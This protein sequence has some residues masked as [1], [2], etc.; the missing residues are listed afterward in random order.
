MA[1]PLSI[2]TAAAAVRPDA[3]DVTAWA[4]DQRV[5]ISSVMGDLAA[6]RRAV[7]ESIAKLGAYPVW[8]EDFGGRDDD[9]QAAYL[10][11]VGSSTIYVGILAR[12]YGR[13]L[14]SRRSA[15]H[16]EYREAERLGLR[17]SVW[18]RADEDF[19]GDQQSF[20]YEVRLFHTTG[21]FT[22]PDDLSTGVT[23]R[24]R[25]IA[26]EDLSPWLKLG[27]TI[28][29]AHDVRDNGKALSVRAS[30]H[31][32]AVVANLEGMRPGVWAGKRET[33]I[34]YG[35][36]SFAVRV[37][38][39]VTHATTARATGVEI[40][41][42]RATDLDRSGT[43]FTVS[44]NGQS[45]SF[46]DVTEI[47]IRHVLFGEPPPRGLFSLGGSISDPLAQMPQTTLP[48]ET[49]N[50]V[51][52]LLV[53]ESLV[54]SGRASRVITLRIAPKGPDGRRVVLTWAGRSD[55]GT[56]GEERTVDGLL[57]V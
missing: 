36:R 16:E 38:S 18:V 5:F 49:H 20:V 42:E 24:L 48:T 22:T 57:R 1:V 19:Q 3:A 40:E 4:A 9:A 25:Q 32:P 55:R 12:T 7:A 51:L 35:G 21:R 13:L 53:T 15:T 29:R 56:L 28:F 37:R 8:F 14:P 6:E 11:E 31:T 2:D 41:L 52:G 17:M 26:A 50:A 30:I 23:A 46:D 27:D 45:Y 33:H 34:T 54:G 44:L 47:N 43:A 39:V 10:G